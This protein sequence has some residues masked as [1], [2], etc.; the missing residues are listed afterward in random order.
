MWVNV[1]SL[2][3]PEAWLNRVAVCELVI[4]KESV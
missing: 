4:M 1:V 3:E 2:P